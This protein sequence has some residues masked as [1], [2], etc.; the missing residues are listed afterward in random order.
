MLVALQQAEAPPTTPGP[1]AD[2]Q[3]RGGREA[4]RK[5]SA[6]QSGAVVQCASSAKTGEEDVV[7]E[8]GTESDSVRSADSACSWGR[9]MDP[10]VPR[11]WRRGNFGRVT[12]NQKP[13]AGHITD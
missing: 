5:S 7:A 8:G 1:A 13:Q 4:R 10:G 2:T 11:Q 3:A 9:K 6:E 12:S